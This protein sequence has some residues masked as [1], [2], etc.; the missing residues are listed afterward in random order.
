M[1]RPCQ[2]RF[3]CLCFGGQ[4]LYCPVQKTDDTFFPDPTGP[5]QVPPPST[6]ASSLI[7]PTAQ[8]QQTEAAAQLLV[9]LSGLEP[10]QQHQQG[11]QGKTSVQVAASSSAN[12]AQTGSL[13]SQPT[14]RHG[15]SYIFFCLLYFVP[16]DLATSFCGGNRDPDLK[17]GRGVLL[18]ESS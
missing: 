3:T 4:V 9:T 15:H 12:I 17:L 5:P 6:S 10:Q 2:V 14:T 18:C 8:Q 16:T 7:S 1:L 11:T 13:P